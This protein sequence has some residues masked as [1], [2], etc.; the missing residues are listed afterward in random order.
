MTEKK[1]FPLEKILTI[2]ASEH[3]Q[4]VGKSLEDY[5]PRGINPLSGSMGDFTNEVPKNAEVV[6][7][8]RHYRIHYG[9]A[10]IPKTRKPEEKG[11]ISGI[12]KEFCHGGLD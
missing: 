7:A 12:F 9:T 4:I 11:L 10:L 8:Y 6:V 5:E 1:T 3:C 2:S